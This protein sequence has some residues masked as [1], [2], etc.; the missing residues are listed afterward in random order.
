MFSFVLGQQLVDDRPAATAPGPGRTPPGHVLDRPGASLDA[1]PDGAVGHRSA[2]ADVHSGPRLD[3]R[4]QTQPVLVRSGRHDD[5]STAAAPPPPASAVRARPPHPSTSNPMALS[6]ETRPPP[7][8]PS[9]MD[10]QATIST[11]S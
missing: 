11:Y 2:T 7:S 10:T 3:T 4:P 6:S 8:A 9:A 1:R 5:N